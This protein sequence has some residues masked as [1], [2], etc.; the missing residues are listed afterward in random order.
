MGKDLNYRSGICCEN[1][2]HKKDLKAF[3]TIAECP[4]VGDISLFALCDLFE[5]LDGE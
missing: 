4:Y 3:N 2:K 5:P 1:C